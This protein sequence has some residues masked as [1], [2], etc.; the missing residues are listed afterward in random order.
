MM[1]VQNKKVI[2]RLSARTLVAKRKKNLVAIFAIILTTVLFTALFTIGGGIIK[3][4]Q[5]ATMRQVGGR[6]MAGVKFVLPEDYEKLSK[7]SAVKNADYRIIVGQAENEELLKVSTEVNYTGAEMAKEMF[8]YPTTGTMPKERLEIA[9][10]TLVLDAL[11]IPHEIGV[12]VPLQINVDG[13]IVK[14]DFILS[15]YWEGDAVA[16][17]QQCWVTR[18][19]CDEVAPTPEQ[20]FYATEESNYAGY[21]MMDFNYGNSWNI[22][23]KTIEL[24]ERNGYDSNQIAYGINWA[25]ATSSVDAGT[26]CFIV[27]LLGLIMASGYLIIYNIFSLNVA[28]DIQSYGLLKTIGTTEKQL[29]QLVKR[30]AVL[31]SVIGI[32]CGLI[33]GAI[34]GQQLFPTII[35]NFNMTGTVEVSMHPLIFI[36]A[37]VFSFL[38]VWISC[39]KPCKLAASVSPVE[40]VRYVDAVYSG[41]KKEK[42]TGKINAFSFAKANM[43]RNKK[44]VTVVVLS[45]S[46]SLV[47]FNFVYSLVSGFDM[48]KFISGSLIGDAMVTDVSIMSPVAMQN[49]MVGI[50]PEI[51]E[52]LAEINGI[53]SLHNVYCD[54]AMVQMDENAHKNFMEFMEEKPEYFS[55][56]E[57]TDITIEMLEEDAVLECQLY[58]VDQWGTEQLEIY[59]GEID[60]EKFQT[61]KY[62]LIN[63][64]GSIMSEDEPLDGM[65]Y[66]VG[67]TLRAELPDGTVKEYEVMAIANLPYPMSCRFYSYLGAGVILP[68]TEYLEYANDEGALLSILSIAEGVK[69]DAAL[70]TYTEN[71]R[72]N[73]TFVSRQTYEKEFETYVN[74]YWLVGGGLSL[75]L[76]LIGILNFTNGVVTGILARKKEFA[77]MEAVGMTGRQ[78]KFMLAWEGI[79]YAVLTAICSIVVG[80]LLNLTLVKMFT[81]GMWF[82]S[83]HFTIMPIIV[84]MPV[85]FLIACIIPVVAYKNMAKVS[86]VERLREIS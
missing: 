64:F 75:I 71:V 16:M 61:G 52:E 19:Y 82:F 69:A 24:L 76:A 23:G 6:S 49:N 20:S 40:A 86:V 79:F 15:G 38:T 33:L 5:E 72:E 57:K 25:Y 41:E 28:G 21:W 51:Q 8:S 78:L 37:S 55:R 43:E 36:G 39:R 2:S 58:G 18:E 50:T 46:L 54:Y 22:E 60:W 47:L 63:T 4:Y 48:E 80:G 14:E 12:T 17:A 59:K 56:A 81:D 9:T 31:L 85:L 73:L 66:D 67:E 42:K 44:K 26:V 3:S 83:S 84:C 62:I 27:L 35:K 65:Y 68:E 74:M 29:K 77:M 53:E 45:L 70:E 7:D 30:Q 34:L 10:S 1:K 13:K 32:P 11:G